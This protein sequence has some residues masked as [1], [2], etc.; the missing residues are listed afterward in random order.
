MGGSSM[1]APA[2][3]LADF[4]RF[5]ATKG[6]QE[7]HDREALAELERR[8]LALPAGLSIRWLGVSG[9]R[10]DYEGHTLLV[11]PYVSRVPLASVIAR[12][13]ALPD[14]ARIGRHIGTPANCVGILVGHTH[15]DHAVDT[16]VIARRLRCPAYGSASLTRLMRLH[17][18]PELG[19][20]VTPYKTYEL[21]PFT[22]TFTPSAHSKLVLG[23]AVPFD[24]ELTCDHLDALSP[25]AYRCGEIYG[26]EIT[27][28]GM[29][30]YHQGSANLIDAAVRSRNVDVFLAGVAGR[31]FTRDYWRRI[32]TRLQPHTIVP[33]HYDDFFRPLDGDMGFT[34]NVN[35]AHVPDE[36][37]AISQDFT[38][39][40]LPLAPEPAP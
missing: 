3:Y 37:H 36:V 28:A 6:S 11:D 19:V 13:A 17:G 33:T 26:I 31:G 29:S 23:L 12:R 27:V 8:P 2:R 7:Q 34:T 24:G 5:A 39:A 1:F 32:L 18:C 30:F 35:L 22:A 25:G 15:F 20:H 14:P 4:A 9:Y 38:V 16:P 40:A 21:G 10:F